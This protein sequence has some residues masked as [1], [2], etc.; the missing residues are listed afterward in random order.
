L[1]NW[2]QH[3]FAEMQWDDLVDTFHQDN[4]QLN[5]LTLE[6]L[7]TIYLQAGLSVLKTP[8]PFSER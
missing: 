3:L 4:H 8:Y 1:G 6:S 7:L 5:N 2:V